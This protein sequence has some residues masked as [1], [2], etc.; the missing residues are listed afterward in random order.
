MF[1]RHLLLH[2]S[3]DTTRRLPTLRPWLEPCTQPCP[4]PS[5]S[6]FCPYSADVVPAGLKDTRI[7]VSSAGFWAPIMRH[8]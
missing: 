5:R 4:P 1:V 8:M 7:L 6:V 2:R 3:G